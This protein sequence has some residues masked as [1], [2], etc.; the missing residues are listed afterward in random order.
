[1]ERWWSHRLSISF[2]CKD[3]GSC[4]SGYGLEINF[5]V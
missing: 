3:F 5:S 1:M 4:G 2:N